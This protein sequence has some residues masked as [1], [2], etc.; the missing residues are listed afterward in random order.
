MT[1]RLPHLPTP[2]TTSSAAQYIADYLKVDV[3]TLTY[4]RQP[5]D[6]SMTFRDAE[7]STHTLHAAHGRPDGII[8]SS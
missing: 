8:F 4:E 3:A 7:G 5:Q 1:D 2:L 6:G